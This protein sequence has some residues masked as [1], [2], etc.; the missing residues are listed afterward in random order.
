[1][2]AHSEI[3]RS[4][5]GMTISFARR[6]DKRQRAADRYG[7]AEWEEQ[8]QYEVAGALGAAPT[9]TTITV[10]FGL[11]FIG[12]SGNQRDSTLDR[13]HLRQG[14]EMLLGPPGL[15][16]YAYV[17]SWQYDADFN[18]TGAIVIVGMHYPA[19][20]IPSA[21][22]PASANVKGIVHL[23]FQGFA[24]MWDPDGPF[25]AGGDQTLGGS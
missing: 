9:E 8:F 25:D 4:I 19:F 23:A 10:P 15:I 22:A 16:P 5:R 12:D 17:A 20:T 18:Y 13:P 1:M 21:Q 2:L 3:Q 14:F 24:A 7:L 6:V 11:L